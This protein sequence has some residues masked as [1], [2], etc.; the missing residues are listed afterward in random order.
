M[1]ASLVISITEI[2]DLPMLETVRVSLLDPSGKR[3]A[4]WD[5]GFAIEAMGA[6]GND[7]PGHERHEANSVPIRFIAEKFGRYVI[8]IE[9]AQ[10]RV[11]RLPMYIVQRTQTS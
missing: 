2:L 9:D 4:A 3:L 6:T 10:N 5:W 1:E 8:Q 11:I 7:L